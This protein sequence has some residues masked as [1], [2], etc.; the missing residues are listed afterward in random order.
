[1]NKK[2]NNIK[3]LCEKK[4]QKGGEIELLSEMLTS[5]SDTH[6]EYTISLLN[7]MLHQHNVKYFKINYEVN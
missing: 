4:N 1:M 5:D 3:K 2:F 6:N 7:N